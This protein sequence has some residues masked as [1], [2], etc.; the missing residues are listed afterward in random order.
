MSKETIGIKNKNETVGISRRNLGISGRTRTSDR[1]A[2][3]KCQI[4]GAVTI[5]GVGLG[6]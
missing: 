2:Q 5:P 1:P 6:N 3:V 4:C